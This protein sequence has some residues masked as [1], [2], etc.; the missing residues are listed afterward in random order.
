M[1]TPDQMARGQWLR[2]ITLDIALFIALL[3]TAVALGAALAH[4]F[5]LANKIGLPA[6]EY[7]IAQ[8]S[9]RGWDRLGYVLL[10]QLVSMLAVSIISGR[11]SNVRV[12]AVFAILSLAIAQ[13]MFWVFTYPANIATQNWTVAPQDW[14]HLRWQ[15]EYSHAVGAA[16]Q[17][18]ALSCLIVAALARGR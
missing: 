1:L 8:K 5:A 12:P 17:F 6:D 11:E 10:I 3:A 15:W 9:Y 2:S 16:F 18:L 14:E 13:A 7:L 4:A